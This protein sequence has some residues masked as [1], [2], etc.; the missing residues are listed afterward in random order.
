ME[1]MM[2]KPREDEPLPCGN[3]PSE[4]IPLPPEE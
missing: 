2:D 1:T 3:P 4:P